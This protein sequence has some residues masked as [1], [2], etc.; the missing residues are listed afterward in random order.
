MTPLRI[1]EQM[2]KLPKHRLWNISIKEWNAQDKREFLK[3]E[4]LSQKAKQIGNVVK[5]ESIYV[6]KQIEKP[7]I[8]GGNKV[9]VRRIS[10]G[11]TYTTIA[12]CIADNNFTYQSLSEMLAIGIDF[13]VIDNARYVTPIIRVDDGKPYR[14]ISLCVK[15]NK[16]SRYKLNE[17]LKVGKIFKYA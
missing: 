4:N 5:L 15:D 1:R 14:S 17:L 16:L 9:K 12:K 2:R 3:M 11:K 8:K 13:R 7:E 10:D 6:K